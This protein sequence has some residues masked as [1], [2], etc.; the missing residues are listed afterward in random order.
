MVAG[1]FRGR[2][3]ALAM[4][5]MDVLLA[6]PPLVLVLAI[7]AYLGQ[8]L[9]NL[10]MTIGFLSIP[11]FARVARAATLTL[12]QREFVTAARALGA[13]HA[14]ILLR[15][16]LPNVSLPL[17]AF[18]LLAVAVTIVVEGALSLLGLGVPPPTASWGSMIGE[19]RESLDIAPWLAFLPAGVMF[20]TVLSFNLVG[21][22]LRA[23][24]D[25]R[26]KAL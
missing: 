21:D 9:L 13:T 26:E 23:I 2:F 5:G 19:G 4:G 7:T 25:P 11:P 18:F 6:F 8:S 3:E 14:R 20:L 1:Y 15:E 12:A 10:S 16:L 24:T 17:L 22:S